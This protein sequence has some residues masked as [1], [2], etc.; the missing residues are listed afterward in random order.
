LPSAI[1]RSFS[2]FLTI[3]WFM[4]RRMGH[5]KDFDGIGHEPVE[6]LERIRSEKRHTNA[7]AL[8]H[9][10]RAFR[11]PRDALLNCPQPAAAFGRRVCKL[12]SL[13]ISAECPVGV[14]DRIDLAISAGRS[15]L[16]GRNS[17]RKFIHI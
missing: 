10:G 9:L 12:K 11:P 3:P 7:E 5:V 8:F 6:E 17:A 16:R 14:P 4:A 2:G 15:W 13:E 1:W